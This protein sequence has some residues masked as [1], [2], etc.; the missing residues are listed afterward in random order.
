MMLIEILFQLSEEKAKLMQSYIPDSEYGR[1]FD[2]MMDMSFI[3]LKKAV[4][5]LNEEIKIRQANIVRTQP[6]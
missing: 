6:L 3:E 1:A 4:E 5:A 2:Q